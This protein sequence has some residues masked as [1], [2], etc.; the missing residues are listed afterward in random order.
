MTYLSYVS[1]VI[2][3]ICVMYVIYMTYVIKKGGTSKYAKC[4]GKTLN[5][6]QRTY[7]S[8]QT[9]KGE[10]KPSRRLS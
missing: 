3:I 7:G 10:A 4:L 1:H 6:I 8:L 5:Y 9:F 2:Y